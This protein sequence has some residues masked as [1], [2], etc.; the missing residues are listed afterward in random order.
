MTY[1]DIDYLVNSVSGFIYPFFRILGFVAVAPF[2]GESAIPSLIKISFAIIITISTIAIFNQSVD[3]DLISL[4]GAIELT[5]QVVIGVTIGFI[6]RIVFAAIDYAGQFMGLMTGFGFATFYDAHAASSTTSISSLFNILLL[7]V[8]ISTDGHL[9]SLSIL[10]QSLY[11]IPIGG[12]F[13]NIDM[14]ML[15]SLGASIFSTGL[16]IALPL[17][18][19]MLII[20]LSLA[21][22]T[23]TAPQL[24]LFM[25]GFPI[26][27]GAG[28]IILYFILPSMDIHFINII[29]HA[30]T[31]IEFI[32]LKN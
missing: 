9:L 12:T 1:I 23:R 15:G 25:I 10:I 4:A 14:S 11:T 20:N 31:A 21:I 6:L 2:F 3:V 32:V 19:F 5:T 13:K 29:N 17:T 16:R 7:L 18:A 30:L 22:L 26:T 28:L 8:Y 24:N 27:L